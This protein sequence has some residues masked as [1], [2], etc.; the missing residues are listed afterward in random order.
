MHQRGST[1]VSPFRSVADT[2][3]VHY[4]GRR[5]CDC[6]AKYKIAHRRGI[7]LCSCK[8]DGLS[9]RFRVGDHLPCARTEYEPSFQ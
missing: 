4:L 8:E 9:A 3:P 6:R 7:A 2:I 5:S 1:S